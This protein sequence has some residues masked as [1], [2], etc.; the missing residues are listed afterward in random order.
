VGGGR[1]DSTKGKNGGVD[2]SKSV[3]SNDQSETPSM[4][5]EMDIDL[6]GSGGMGMS[7]VHE[8]TTLTRGGVASPSS[9]SNKRT[10][11]GLNGEAD[12]DGNGETNRHV[13]DDVHGLKI[14]SDKNTTSI[15]GRDDNEWGNILQTVGQL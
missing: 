13:V 15:I 2:W 6:G 1:R 7:N 10:E 4:F 12:D 14:L 9:S 8:N 11:S 5:G 3:A